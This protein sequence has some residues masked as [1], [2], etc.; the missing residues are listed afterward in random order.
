MLLV[1][2]SVCLLQSPLLVQYVY[3]SCVEKRM[4]CATGL[5]R[6]VPSVFV[7]HSLGSDEP[8][9]FSLGVR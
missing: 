9:F 3:K 8:E 6:F 4:L 5:V 2:G 1:D 7:A